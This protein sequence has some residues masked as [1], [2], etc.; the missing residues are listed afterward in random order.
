MIV[1]YHKGTVMYAY[2]GLFNIKEHCYNWSGGIPLDFKQNICNSGVQPAPEAP[3]NQNAAGLT[4]DKTSSYDCIGANCDT[5]GGTF[6]CC[7]EC[8]WENCQLPISISSIP[9]HVQMTVA[10]SVY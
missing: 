6:V 7:D 2:K 1:A 9:Q 8:Q 10:I 4:F 3:E 5:Y